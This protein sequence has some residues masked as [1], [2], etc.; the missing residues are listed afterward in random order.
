MGEGSEHKPVEGVEGEAIIVGEKVGITSTVPD[1]GNQETDVD[2]K[3]T[4]TAENLFAAV[5][6][7]GFKTMETVENLLKDYP[8]FVNELGESYHTTCTRYIEG[9]PESLV[10][11]EH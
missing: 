11:N 3:P 7:G 6:Y 10:Q 2:E 9:H 8:Q 5:R 4:R 1:T